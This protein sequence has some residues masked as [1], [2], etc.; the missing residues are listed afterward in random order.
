MARALWVLMIVGIPL[1]ILII[2]ATM[3]MGEL[4]MRRVRRKPR[5]RAS[6][7]T[8]YCPASDLAE[9][10]LETIQQATDDFRLRMRAAFDQ[11]RR[12][13]HATT[14]ILPATSKGVDMAIATLIRSSNR[15]AVSPVLKPEGQLPC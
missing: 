10:D 2:A 1:M 14:A 5:M 9:P 6:L 4:E 8:E 3:Q 13:I 12:D 15:L 7:V 11:F